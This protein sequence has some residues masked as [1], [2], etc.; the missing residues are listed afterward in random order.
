MFNKENLNWIGKTRNSSVASDVDVRVSVSSGRKDER[1]S[2]T[3]AFY[4]ECARLVSKTEYIQ[5]AEFKNRIF[6][7]EAE[8]AKGIKLSMNKQCDKGTRYAKFYG[9]DVSARFIPF[10]GEYELKYDEFYELYYIE[11]KGE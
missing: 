11:K 1:L 9:E 3:F 10:E 2:C 4:K 5:V 8:D 6:F 7:R